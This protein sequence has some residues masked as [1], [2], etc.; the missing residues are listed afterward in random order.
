MTTL[1]HSKSTDL[2]VL[3]CDEL[4]RRCRGNPRYSM[5]AFARSL[6]ISHS[7][8]SMIMSHKR[9]LSKSAARKIATGLDLDP[10]TAQEALARVATAKASKKGDGVTDREFHDIDVDFF[11]ILADWYCYAILSLLEIPGATFDRHWISRRLSISPTEAKLAMER[12][13][14]VG[15]VEQRDGRWRQSG[16]QLRTNTEVSTTATRHFHRQVLNKALH[17]LDHEPFER[18]VF[19]A[20]TLPANRGDVTY[21]RGR[22]EAVK[23]LLSDE[24][25]AK[26]G[27]ATDVYQ[28]LIQYFPVTPAHSDDDKESS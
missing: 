21:A 8:L 12:L 14:R 1:E 25:E 27:E 6:K 26:P 7:L 15:L 16:A 17:A 28:L 10:A 23:V 9:S 19:A 22:I 3:L 18:R 20:M 5:R 2:R 24:L 11:A 13:L 4:A